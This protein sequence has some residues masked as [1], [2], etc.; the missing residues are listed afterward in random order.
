MNRFSKPLR[1]VA[2]AVPFALGVASPAGAAMTAAPATPVA[3]PAPAVPAPS[4]G[5]ADF[6]A[7]LAQ[8]AAAMAPAGG[9][10][11]KPSAG[12]SAKPSA[13]SSA[14]PSTGSNAAPSASPAATT[15]PPPSDSLLGIVGPLVVVCLN[16]CNGLQG[17]LVTVCLNNCGPSSTLAMARKD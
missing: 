4:G 17:T 5:G 16:H 15:P 12:S 6:N 13:D 3:V 9:S 1:A 10:S 8:L 7:L 14:A 11:A 2:L